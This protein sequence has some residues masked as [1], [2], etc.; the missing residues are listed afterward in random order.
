M[1]FPLRRSPTPR[2]GLFLALTGSGAALLAAP[3]TAQGPRTGLWDSPTPRTTLVELDGHAVRIRTAATDPHRSPGRPIVVF[4]AGFGSTLTAWGPLLEEVAGIVPVVA[5][6]RAGIGESEWDGVEPTFEHVTGRLRRLLDEIGAEP[7]FVLV[8]HSFG[9]DLVRYFAGFHPEETVGLVL[10][11]PVTNSP[12]DFVGA[13]EEIGE[14]RERALDIYD[15][16]PV[17]APPGVRA[18]TR[19]VGAYFRAD[20]EFDLPRPTDIPV[21]ILFAG[22]DPPPEGGDTYPF[23]V[24][25]H[26][27]RWERRKIARLGEWI[28]QVPLGEMTIVPSSG[29]FVHLDEPEL[30][31]EAV[32]RVVFP[33]IPRVLLQELDTRGPEAAVARYHELEASYPPD[34]FDEDVLNDLGYR[35]IRAERP[36]DAIP[37]FQLNRDEYP[38]L[39]NPW[40]SLAD[41]YR[42]AGLPQEEEATRA[43]LL[44]LAE[45]RGD[46]RAG[47]YRERLARVRAELGGER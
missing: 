20:R 44:E 34:R 18:E 17:G 5:Y 27:A 25:A 3:A 38:E 22:L 10:L 41:G 33:P 32:R 8:G 23:D 7:P 47:V 19:M 35:L 26:L 45:E 28:M 37:I 24:V 1:R 40:D 29:H 21:S 16:D 36:Q 4:E 15:A 9:G 39:L 2:L 46:A 43:R 14:D 42:A 31:L 6:D 13:L 12:E 11:D 30:A